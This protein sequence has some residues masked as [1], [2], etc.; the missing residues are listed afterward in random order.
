MGIFRLSTGDDGQSHL[1]EQ[2]LG[3]HPALRVESLC[4]LAYIAS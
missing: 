2:M 1:E 4:H 3:A